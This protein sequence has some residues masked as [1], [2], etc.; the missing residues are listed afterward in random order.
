M[1]GQVVRFDALRSLAAGSISGSFTAVGSSFGHPMRLVKFV[2]ATDALL[3]LS[4]DGVTSNDVI[5]AGGFA[6]YDMT[7]NKTLPDTTFVFQNGTQVYVSGAPTVNSFYV[8][9]VYGQ[10]D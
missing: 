2:N 6:L 10:G 7:T 5:P 8:V 1:P 9:A 4:F 3:T